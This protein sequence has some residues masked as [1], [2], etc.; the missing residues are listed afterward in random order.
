MAAV[1]CGAVSL[2]GCASLKPPTLIVD[3]LH[4]GDVG[5]TGAALDVSFRVRN[6]NPEPLLIERFEYELSLNGHRLGRGYVA[7]GLELIGFAEKKVDSRFD[8]NFLR[9]PGAV[10]EV[11]LR[12]RVKAKVKGTFYVRQETGIKKLKFSADADARLKR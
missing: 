10:R 7:D 12:D 5:V 4:M 3:G 6:P 2:A 11:L 8:V 1:L 9:V